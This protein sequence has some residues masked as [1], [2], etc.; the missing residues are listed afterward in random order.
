MFMAS[1]KKKNQTDNFNSLDASEGGNKCLKNTN[2]TV[3]LLDA[4]QTNLFSILLWIGPDKA[5]QDICWKM[6]ARLWRVYFA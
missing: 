2:S 1:Y 4:D 6:Y 3:N 5:R